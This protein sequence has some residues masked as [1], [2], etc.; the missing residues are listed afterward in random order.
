MTGLAEDIGACIQ[1]EDIG[2]EAQ[3]RTVS[4]ARP[5]PIFLDLLFDTKN[6]CRTTADTIYAQSPNIICSID[7]SS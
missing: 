2:D 7:T 4:R 6:M 1:F 3:E 5:F